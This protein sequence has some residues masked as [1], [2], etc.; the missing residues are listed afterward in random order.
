MKKGFTLV[1]LLAVIVILGVLALITTMSVGKILK[2]SKNTL[3][4][5]QKSNVEQAAK[6]YYIKEGMSSNV[7]CINI[8]DLISKGYVEGKEVLDPKTEET[9]PGSVKINAPATG[10]FTY[11]YQSTTCE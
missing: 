7:D 3:S 4:D 10:Q 11:E 9:L 2:D 6:A 1:E 8:T 5:T